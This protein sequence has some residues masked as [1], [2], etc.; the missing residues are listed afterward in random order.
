MNID[1]TLVLMTLLGLLLHFL[2]RYGE[3]WR[4]SGKLGPGAYLMQDPIAWAV[5]AIGTLV[6]YVLL[7]ELGPL[8]GL[9]ATPAGAFG[10]GYM[11]SSLAAKLPG[12]L[13]PK[14]AG[15]R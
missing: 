8:V 6:A 2:S 10:A 1:A 11:G 7:P 9:S 14:I 12:L 13:A 3:F 4:S 5:A 15:T